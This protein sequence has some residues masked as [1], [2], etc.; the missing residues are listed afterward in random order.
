[1]VDVLCILI[2]IT[3]LVLNDV[4][5]F[6]FSADYAFRNVRTLVKFCVCLF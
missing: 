2:L 5:I 1:M 6:V 4:D 3:Q